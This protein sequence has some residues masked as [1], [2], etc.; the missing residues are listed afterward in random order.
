MLKK[1]LS[2][3]TEETKQDFVAN[4]QQIKGK[5]T[6][7]MWGQQHILLQTVRE[8]GVQILE[9]YISYLVKF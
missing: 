2:D 8:N 9:K 5:K 7:G 6:K 1:R 3:R 4:M